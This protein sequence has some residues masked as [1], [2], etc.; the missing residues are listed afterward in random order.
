[1]VLENGLIVSGTP[2]FV[3]IFKVYMSYLH[4]HVILAQISRLEYSLRG[5]GSLYFVQNRTQ[6]GVRH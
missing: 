5:M 4:I 1:M 6:V 2:T 3:R